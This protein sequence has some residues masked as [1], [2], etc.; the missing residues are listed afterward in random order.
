LEGVKE[1][2]D[3]LGVFEGVRA[4]GVLEVEELDKRAEDLF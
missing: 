3:L 2:E 1:G 4:E